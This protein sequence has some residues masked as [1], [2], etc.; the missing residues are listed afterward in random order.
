MTFRTRNN[1][2][3]QVVNEI[4]AGI[5]IFAHNIRYSIIKEGKKMNFNELSTTDDRIHLM[6]K[7]SSSF[8]EGA[9]EIDQ[10][11]SFPFDHIEELVRTGYKG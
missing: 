9:A 3:I 2:Y 5:D 11:G 1:H 6:K 10:T 7:L 8:S 4:F